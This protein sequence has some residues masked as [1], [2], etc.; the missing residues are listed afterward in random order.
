MPC[1]RCPYSHHFKAGVSQHEYAKRRLDGDCEHVVNC[2]W[3]PR[4][5]TSLVV[6]E[7]SLA[8]KIK[9]RKCFPDQPPHPG[10]GISL[11]GTLFVHEGG[12]TECPYENPNQGELFDDDTV[13]GTTGDE[14]PLGPVDKSGGPYE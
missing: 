7:D 1:N 13:H 8:L 2:P 10:G 9:C 11:H 12:A 6:R 4:H 5:S 3:K 14:S